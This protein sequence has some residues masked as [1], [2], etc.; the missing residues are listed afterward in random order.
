MML[1]RV[2]GE[3]SGVGE[4][5]KKKEGATV[6]VVS[7]SQRRQSP[8]LDALQ[9]RSKAAVDPGKPSLKLRMTS[10]RLDCVRFW[11]RE[12]LT[13]AQLCGDLRSC[14]GCAEIVER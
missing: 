10:D 7:W 8:N 2:G 5:V 4:G 3:R 13:A 12:Q 1:A 9:V 6:V 11:L 14:G